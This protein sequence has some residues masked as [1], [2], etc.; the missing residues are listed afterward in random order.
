[1]RTK[2]PMYPGLTIREVTSRQRQT[3]RQTIEVPLSWLLA[4]CALG[5]VV[6]AKIACLLTAS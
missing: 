4:A 2:T 1:M 6:G 3:H 5:F